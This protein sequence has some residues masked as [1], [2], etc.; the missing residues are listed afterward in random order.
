MSGL[1]YGKERYM[2]TCLFTL[3]IIILTACTPRLVPAPDSTQVASQTPM[4]GPSQPTFTPTESDIPQMPQN[5]PTPTPGLEK[6]IE[7]AKNDL[8]GRLSLP[9]AQIILIDARS[10]VWPNSSVGCPQ[11][12]ML[13]ADVLTAGYL[14]LLNANGRDYEYHAGKGPQVIYCENPTPPVPG[15]PDDV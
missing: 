15:A 13:Y 5:N 6:L 1:V 9:A 14:I 12:G 7:T 3:I 8:A 10:V 11:P 2:R 4:S